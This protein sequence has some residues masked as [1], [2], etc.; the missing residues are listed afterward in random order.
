[1]ANYLVVVIALV[2]FCCWGAILTKIVMR[3]FPEPGEEDEDEDE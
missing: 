3:M 1:M 2:L